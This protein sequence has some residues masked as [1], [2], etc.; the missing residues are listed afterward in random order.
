MQ[1]CRAATRVTDDEDGPIDG[2]PLDS[3]VDQPVEAQRA[4]RDQFTAL[5]GREDAERS[6]ALPEGRADAPVEQRSSSHAPSSQ[7]AVATAKVNPAAATAMTI[8]SPS[9]MAPSRRRWSRASTHAVLAVFPYS[10]WV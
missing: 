10:L 2:L 5:Q 3:R 4:S 1:E 9:E 8:E 6:N 7:I